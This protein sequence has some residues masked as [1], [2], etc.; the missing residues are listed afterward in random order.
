MKHI[1]KLKKLAKYSEWNNLNSQAI[2]DIVSRI[3]K[4]YK[5]FFRN[6]K[7]KVKAGMPTFKKV[8][9]YKSFTLKQ[10]GYK[11]FP[12][13]TIEI[14]GK[15]YKYYKSRDIQ[16][17]V[18]TV[19]VKRD[20]LGDI[21]IYI[22]CE[23][24]FETKT[25]TCAG[26]SV[27]FDFGLKTYLVGSDGINIESPLF[28]KQS[29]KEIKKLNRKL[30]KKKKG[31]R[32]RFKSKINLAKAHKRITDKRKDFQF[33]LALDLVQKYGAICLEDLNIKGMQRMWG[34]KVSDLSHS[35]FVDILKYQATK[36][37]CLIVEIDRFYP[38]S[39]TCSACGHV[40]KDLPLRVREWTCPNC[41]T[42][43]DRDKNAAIIIHRVG[44]ST[45]G[46]EL[47]RPATAGLAC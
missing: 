13:N 12:D 10:T 21:Y 16:G 14:M 27:G 22:V 31:S 29:Q 44:I 23:G 28:F 20:A 33:K 1:T 5:L 2:Q 26:K 40:L 38:S 18:K 43:H 30:S 6:K 17:K 24:T 3:D 42:H 37:G 34:K 8:K 7:H 32:N 25:S 15:K 4:A 19:T 45:L 41:D 35:S 11:L 39:K 47:V 9:K 46:G 36:T